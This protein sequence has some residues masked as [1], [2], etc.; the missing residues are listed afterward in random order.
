MRPATAIVIGSHP[1]YNIGGQIAAG[2]DRRGWKVETPTPAEL[3]VTSALAVEDHDWLADALVYSAG[4][5]EPDWIWNQ[6]HEQ[7]YHQVNVSMTAGLHV[8]ARYA[9]HMFTE[10]ANPVIGYKRIILMGSRAA[11][12]PHRG[13]VP[14]NAAK[15]GLRAAV[16]TLARELHPHG[17]RVFLIEP[18]AVDGTD[19]GPRVAE[20]ARRMGLEDRA[21]ATRGTF[22]Q[23]LKPR[24][25][26]DL[27]VEI[28]SGSFDRLAG[29]PIPYGGGP[30]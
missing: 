13:Q 27:A 10:P 25:V 2:L 6:H 9:E 5:C 8:V 4:Y 3:D 7:I 11:E 18:G 28:L 15:A 22:G 30:Q 16:S 1:E 26:A 29:A 20:G 21:G 12:T 14:Y 24:E 19:Y 17:F 23:N